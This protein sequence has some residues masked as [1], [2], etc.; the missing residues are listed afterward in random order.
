MLCMSLW[1]NS[2]MQYSSPSFASSGSECP[3]TWSLAALRKNWLEWTSR[4]R[5]R[6]GWMGRT[7]RSSV[8][9]DCK[10]HYGCV[11]TTRDMTTWKQDRLHID[12]Q[13]VERWTLSRP[14]FLEAGSF[15]EGLS[16]AQNVRSRI[17]SPSGASRW[18]GIGRRDPQQVG[19]SSLHGRA[20]V[21]PHLPPH[22]TYGKIVTDE[23]A[24]LD[25]PG[26][27]RAAHLHRRQT[28]EKRSFPCAG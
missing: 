28:R 17:M 10:P 7:G 16:E 8:N 19:G 20:S 4:A 27:A 9:L 13:I 2:G 14:T 22:P 18:F 26:P 21:L 15:Q 3:S 6:R 23:A 24:R 11:T 1:P 12:G 5:T 25:P